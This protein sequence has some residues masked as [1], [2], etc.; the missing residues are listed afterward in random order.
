MFL[1]LEVGR[2][3]LE[4]VLKSGVRY[5]YLAE[6]LCA[7]R[8]RWKQAAHIH[9]EKVMQFRYKALTAI[10]M[11]AAVVP[12]CSAQNAGDAND[13]KIM[14]AFRMK[15]WE[16]VHMHDAAK[17]KEHIDT[18]K[19]LGCEVKTGQHDG[20]TDIQSRS[21]LWKLLALDTA[22]QVTSWKAWLKHAGFEVLDSK[23]AS[24]KPVKQPAGQP[25]RE[26]VQ[27]RLSQWKAQHIHQA[28]A[29][30][31]ALV[32]YRALG[33]ETEKAQHSGHTDVKV[34]CVE[35]REVELPD[36]QTAHAWQDYLKKA[37]FETKHE[38]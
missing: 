5:V 9:K 37:G 29:A 3:R 11:F 36:H 15:N 2:S 6:G 38:H 12:V 20:H 16:T 26:I 17:A 7:Q 14:I 4:L 33:C 25:P 23:L 35:W 28:N 10:L 34:R 32:I 27:F 21:V 18:L 8:L 31:E 13:K 30:A 1:V 24:D 19:T 22:E